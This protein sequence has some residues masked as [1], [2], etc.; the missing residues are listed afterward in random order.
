MRVEAARVREY[1]ELSVAHAFGLRAERRVRPIE[2]GAVGADA[3]Y[4]DDPRTVAADLAL[5]RSS[6]GAQ[7]VVLEFRGSRRSPCDEVG[8]PTATGQ[9]L[10][11]IRGRKQPRREAGGVERRPETVAR[12]REVLPLRGRHQAGVDADK[13]HIEIRTD[14]IG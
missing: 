11:L 13:E 12:P 9:Q 4:G 7:F 14:D 1:P 2:C 8:D 5:E 10:E 6:S 3:D